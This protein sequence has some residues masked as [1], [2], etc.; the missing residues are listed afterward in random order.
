M[1]WLDL[2]TK[3]GEDSMPSFINEEGERSREFSDKVA[4][5]NAPF[6]KEL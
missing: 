5:L 1:L 4:K 6:E 2:Y 3:V